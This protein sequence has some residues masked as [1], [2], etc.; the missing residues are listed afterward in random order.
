MLTIVFDVLFGVPVTIGKSVLE[1]IGQE[2]DRECLLTEAS[3]KQRLQELQLT[4]QEGGI[5]EGDY[6]TLEAELIERLRVIRNQLQEGKASGSA[7]DQ[8]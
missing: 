7:T 5:S 4:L 6:D 3:I 2:I 1:G 8:E